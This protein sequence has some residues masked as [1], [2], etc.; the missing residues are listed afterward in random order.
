M[1][2]AIFASAFHPH[3]GGVEELCRQLAHEYQARGL[4]VIV[5]TNRWPRDLPASELYEG[6]PVFRPA[7][8]TPDGGWKSRLSF[9]LTTRAVQR[10]TREIL[11]Q[12]RIDLV[13]VQ[14]VG[15]N[16]FYAAKAAAALRLPLVVTLQGELSMDATGLFR[17]SAFARETL[18][19][20][21]AQATAVTACSRQTLTEAEEFLG[22]PLGSKGRVIYNGIKAED[23]GTVT[24]FASPRPYV[25][26]IGRQV[27]QKGFDVLLRAMAWVFQQTAWPGD[28]VLAGDGP[29]HARLRALAAELGIA[30]RVAFPGKVERANVPTLFAGCELFVLPSRHEPLGIVNLE[31]MAAG[32]PV[33]ATRV[34]GVPEIVTDGDN[35]LLVSP[36]NA[37]EMGAAISKLL[38]DTNLST[39]I[40]VC[41]RTKACEFTWDAIAV[42]YL[43]VY[44]AARP[45]SPLVCSS[46][47]SLERVPY[48]DATNSRASARMDAAG[49]SFSTSASWPRSGPPDANP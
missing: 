43:E 25:L 19:R 44:A 17:R 30:G 42:Q 45:D 27:P 33:V 15:C 5:L 46:T 36:E 37:E 14:C 7:M 49:A 24:P 34:G 32:K 41:G 13:H 9:A 8:R 39:K 10:Q 18:R 28:L 6:I 29:E 3:M 12:N 22:A 47:V 35:G 4:E 2:I 16:A 31:A 11:R 21:V 26:G 20:T 48:G 1:K 38:V 23:F 40:G